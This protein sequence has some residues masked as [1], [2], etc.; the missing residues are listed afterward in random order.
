MKAS[1]NGGKRNAT[2]GVFSKTSVKHCIKETNPK[3]NGLPL[4]LSAIKSMAGVITTSPVKLGARSGAAA[5]GNQNATAPA[6]RCT[7][8]R[9]GA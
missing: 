1:Q 8:E 4:A 7:A 2:Q 9:H 6:D 5:S 3:G